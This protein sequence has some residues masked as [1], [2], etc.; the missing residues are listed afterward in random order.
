[1]PAEALAEAGVV[2]R[3]GGGKFI[4]GEAMPRVTREREQARRKFEP[5]GLWCFVMAILGSL[6]V[7]GDFNPPIP[8]ADKITLSLLLVLLA[9]GLVLKKRIWR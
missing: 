2:G 1:M 5:I 7:R 8:L 3:K 6:A 4:K 9:I